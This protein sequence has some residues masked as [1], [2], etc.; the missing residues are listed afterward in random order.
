MSNGYHVQLNR[1]EAKIKELITER[2]EL[3]DQ[4]ATQ[5]NQSAQIAELTKR[6]QIA[7]DIIRTSKLESD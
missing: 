4:L 3:R 7:E 6:L 1:L 5:P 2:D